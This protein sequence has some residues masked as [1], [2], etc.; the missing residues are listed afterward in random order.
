MPKR[1]WK[2]VQPHSLN[3][4]IELCIEHARDKRN[5]S[6][7]QI[8]DLCRC[9]K[10]TLYK[11][12]ERGSMPA[13]LIRPFEFACGIDF[14]SRWLVVSGGRLVVDIA[15]GR[16]QGPEDMQSLQEIT[17]GAVGALIKFYNDQATDEETLGA[18]LSAMERLAWHKS[19]VEKTRQPELPFEDHA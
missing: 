7:D 1:N 12:M 15:F 18:V 2:R 13:D 19:N 8:A 14:V 3:H 6:V 5:L 17:L 11:Y 9:N 10:W 16:K 4:A